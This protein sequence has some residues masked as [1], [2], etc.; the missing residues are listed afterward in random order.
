MD[1]KIYIELKQKTNELERLNLQINFNRANNIDYNDIIIKIELKYN[2][3]VQFKKDN[4]L[5]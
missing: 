5:L 3:L 4:H 1:N 2:E